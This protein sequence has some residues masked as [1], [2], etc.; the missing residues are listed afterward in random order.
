MVFSCV[1]KNYAMVN[2]NCVST[3]VIREKITELPLAPL[4]PFDHYISEHDRKM[5]RKRQQSRG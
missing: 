4:F 5:N 3:A 2:N 1:G